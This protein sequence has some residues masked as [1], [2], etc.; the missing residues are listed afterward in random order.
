MNG[1]K[2]SKAPQP[3]SGRRTSA[4]VSARVQKSSESASK[5]KRNKNID[6]DDQIEG[7]QST[8]EHTS[9]SGSELEDNED[10][11]EEREK[12]KRQKKSELG[13]PPK[14]ARTK[15]NT[16]SLT[17]RTTPKKF[18]KSKKATPTNLIE[19]AKVAGGLYG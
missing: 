14:R 12:S 8:S 2:T 9:E 1:T 19:S 10:E 13:P 15:G 6:G 7:E 11:Q 4:R 5:R 16:V 18:S 3:Q 17:I